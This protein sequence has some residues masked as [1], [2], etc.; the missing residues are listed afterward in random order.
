[1]RQD[2]KRAADYLR[3]R[4]MGQEDGGE[5][6]VGTLI[7]RNAELEAALAKE[8]D[9][10]SKPVTPAKVRRLVQR[11]WQT[12]HESTTREDMYTNLS[13]LAGVALSY[14]QEYAALLEDLERE[15]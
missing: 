12:A 13:F 8:P 11:I 4:S 5:D 1:M 7:R 3:E 2:K 10:L 15:G 14:L 9:F 6:P